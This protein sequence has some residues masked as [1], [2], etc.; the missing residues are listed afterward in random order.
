MLLKAPI[1]KSLITL[2]SILTYKHIWE[3]KSS[4]EPG[5]RADFVGQREASA[6]IPQRTTRHSVINNGTRKKEQDR[7]RE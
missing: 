4:H 1:R 2:G 7:K 3:I 6:Q 5:R